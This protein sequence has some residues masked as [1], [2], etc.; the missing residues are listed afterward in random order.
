MYGLLSQTT[1]AQTLEP[2]GQGKTWTSGSR[3]MP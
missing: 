1:G 3:Y 2:Q